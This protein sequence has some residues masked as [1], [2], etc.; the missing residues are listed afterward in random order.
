MGESKSKKIFSIDQYL[1]ECHFVALEKLDKME[2]PSEAVYGLKTPRPS[3]KFD[4][5]HLL[6]V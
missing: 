1:I 3:G 2:N 6:S 5:L 4:T